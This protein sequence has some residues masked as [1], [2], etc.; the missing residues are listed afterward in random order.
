MTSVVRVELALSYP[1]SY[2]KEGY[3]LT[4]IIPHVFIT[5]RW[6]ARTTSQAR[7]PPSGGGGSSFSLLTIERCDSESGALVSV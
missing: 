5:V 4:L 3:I 7:K 2:M 6:V 1:N